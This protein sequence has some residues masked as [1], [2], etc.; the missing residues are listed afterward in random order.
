MVLM[1]ATLCVV[2][3]CLGAILVIPAQWSTEATVCRLRQTSG[4]LSV[5]LGLN[6]YFL[7]CNPPENC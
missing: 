5:C 7:H 3:V 2:S 4:I 1:A 6:Y